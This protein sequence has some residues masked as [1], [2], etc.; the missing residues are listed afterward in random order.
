MYA[1]TPAY[2]NRRKPLHA[3]ATFKQYSALRASLLWLSHARPDIAAFCSLIG[4]KAE[5]GFAP[6]LI[7]AIKIFLRA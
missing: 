4:S 2:V 3:D 7:V 1:T 6:A 5:K